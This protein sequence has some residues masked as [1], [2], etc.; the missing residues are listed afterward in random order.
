MFVLVLIVSVLAAVVPLVGYLTFI[1]W[2]D[3]Y[4][5]EPIWLTVLTFLWGAIGGVIGALVFASMFQLGVEAA[6]GHGHRAAAL[7]DAIGAVV[8][9][10][11]VEEAT[12]G[13]ILLFLL[14]SKH[15]D[16]ATDGL[17]YGAATGLGFAMTE[18]FLYFLTVYQQ[19]GAEAWVSNIVVRT[20]FSAVVHCCASGS[21]GFF[22]GLSRYRQGF[23]TKLVFLPMGYCAGMAI[24]AFWNGSMVLGGLSKGGGVF[25]LG[26]FVLIPVIAL[27][28]LAITQWSLH[29]EH[30]MIRREL[31]EE[32]QLGFIPR[33]HSAI[34]PYYLKR[35]RKGWL[36]ANV[37]HDQ[38]VRV[39]TLLAFRK[40]QVRVRTPGSAQQLM[41]DVES[42]RKDVV[43]MIL[44]DRPP[45]GT[46][47]RTSTA[48]VEIPILPPPGGAGS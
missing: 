6:L 5:R 37:P 32:E 16:N 30:K 12:K 21:L 33:G 41:R 17:I 23:F 2:L 20:L 44:G 11:V 27:C 45:L 46:T 39:A 25:T 10:P 1:W 13:L 9:A 24:H 31:E 29:V 26:A 48:Y 22:L 35:R 8:I 14:L 19:G 40:S 3:R 4:E 43:R 38:Y 7:S 15:F 42:L 34:L 36:Q 28:L 18:N 47:S